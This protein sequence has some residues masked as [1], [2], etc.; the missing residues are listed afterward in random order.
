MECNIICQRMQVLRSAVKMHGEEGYPKVLE[1]YDAMWSRIVTGENCTIKMQS[2]ASRLVE[3]FIADCLEITS[4]D[5][6]LQSKDVYKQFTAWCHLE[7]DYPLNEAPNIR[8][9]GDEMG[10]RFKRVRQNVVY[11]AGIKFKE[12]AKA[13]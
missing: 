12:E 11:Y 7:K 5:H 13:A 3:A 1:A 2:E 9:F 8:I 10:A 4:D 6:K